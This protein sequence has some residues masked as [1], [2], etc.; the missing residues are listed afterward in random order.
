MGYS[1]ILGTGSFLPEQ[2]LTNAQ[3]AER[4]DTSDEWIVSRTG[5]H[6]R[7]IA[8]EEHKT[9]DLALKA[10]EAAIQSAGIDKREIDLIIVATTTPDMV[11]PS[12]AC[13]LQEKLG[14]PGCAAFDVQAVCA[15]F[16]FA[17]VTANNYIKSGMARRALVVGAEIM[18]RVLDWDD[19]RTCV[20]FGDGAGA[21]ILG[22]SEE[23]GILHAKLAA[24]G[25]YKDILNTPAQIS[26]GKIQGMPYLHMDGPAV[27]KFA[28]K[29]LS[30]IAAKTLAEAGVDKS[31]VDWLVPHQ[32][33][34]RIIE[35]TAKHLG[36]PMERVIVTLP[37]QGNTSAASIPLALDCAVRDGRIRPGQTVLL[38]G[39]GGGFAWGAVLLKI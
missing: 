20:L 10:A 8:A 25:R 7:H 17:L 6:A 30:D 35:S 32:A 33:N 39:I 23:P 38:E 9:S 28:V 34:L 1:R 26:G 2:V 3:L 4:V 19:R 14:I 31:E 11:F 22:D 16:M 36:L 15:G 12:T 29:A 37:Q 13:L 27:F 21:V 24:D 18:S 5:I